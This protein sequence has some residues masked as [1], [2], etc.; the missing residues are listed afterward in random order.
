MFV[1]VLNS[2][3]KHSKTWENK[4]SLILSSR[5][6]PSNS[7]LAM[8]LEGKMT[9]ASQVILCIRFLKNAS[10]YIFLELGGCHRRQGW[11]QG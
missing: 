6:K 2:A 1:F 9:S 4:I 8:H 11:Q 5:R 7:M 10:M 3:Q